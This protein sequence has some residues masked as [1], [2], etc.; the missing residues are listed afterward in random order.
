MLNIVRWQFWKVENRNAA[1]DEVQIL[2]HSGQIVRYNR[3]AWVHVLGGIG[4]QIKN[5]LGYVA[6]KSAR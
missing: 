5:V 3:E 2:H 6:T 1:P 4:V